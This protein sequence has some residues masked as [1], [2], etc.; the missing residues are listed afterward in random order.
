LA[1]HAA[2]EDWW[3]GFVSV[4][5]QLLEQS[6]IRPKAIDALCCSLPEKTLLLLDQAFNPL[7]PAI[8]GQLDSRAETGVAALRR[9]WPDRQLQSHGNLPLHASALLP[10]LH[11]LL[12]QHPE[13]GIKAR[14]LA[15]GNSYLLQRLTGHFVTDYHSAAL[16]G[17]FETAA[18]NWA[19]DMLAS[20][21]ARN[22][23]PELQWPGE[24]AGELSREAAALT[25]LNA[26]LSVL[27]GSSA[28]LTETLKNGA[29]QPGNMTIHYGTEVSLIQ[30][31]RQCRND[32]GLWKLPYLFPD[33]RCLMGE[34]LQSFRGLRH[35]QP[36]EHHAFEDM[37][38]E[39]GQSPAGA[40]EL[41]TL[42]WFQ[43]A[44]T[45]VHDPQA[46][47]IL[48]GLKLSHNR[49]DIFRSLLEGVSHTMAANIQALQQAEPTQM[50][51]ADGQGTHNR[52][53]LQATSDITG[54]RQI[55]R[56]NHFGGELGNALLAAFQV[57][58]LVLPDVE[59]I[60]P[61][62]EVITPR[63]ELARMYQRHHRI[64]QALYLQNRALMQHMDVF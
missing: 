16:S 62:R 14:Y 32:T 5:H 18:M 58:H 42:P 8:L 34:L 2:Q 43:G 4:I 53:W 41:I 15:V 35:G 48:F 11:A 9:Q 27:T 26:G 38:Y 47:A 49:S 1:E 46:K 10:L 29:T 51:H 44:R 36:D 59:H 60:N 31:V 63:P 40:D 50:I 39:A 12:R 64:F 20:V 54:L 25:G 21:G 57:G 30:P 22:W 6:R 37:S 17:V 7:H 23:M 3:P 19:E 13:L 28:R 33:S 55:V 61:V 45:P 24:I 56:E 52:S